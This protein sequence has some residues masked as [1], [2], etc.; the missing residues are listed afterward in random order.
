[1]ERILKIFERIRIA[2]RNSVDPVAKAIGQVM[3]ADAVSMSR[4]VGAPILVFLS[5]F[6]L[7]WW[8]LAAY[9]CWAL[10]DALDGAVSVARKRLG[11][12]DDPKFGKFIDPIS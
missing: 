7:P 12:N 5:G 3:S 1:M 9:I 8:A 11:Y 4:I 10:T 6:D 2:W